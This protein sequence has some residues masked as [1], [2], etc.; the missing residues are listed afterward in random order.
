MRCGMRFSAGDDVLQ[1]PHH[2]EQG[3]SARFVAAVRAPL[4]A[5]GEKH[6]V[7][8]EDIAFSVVL[9]FF[10]QGFGRHRGDGV[11][12][13]EH[14]SSSTGAAGNP[15][16]FRKNYA[17]I[18]QVF[19]FADEFLHQQGANQARQQLQK[20]RKWYARMWAEQARKA[21]NQPEIS[22]LTAALCPDFR[23]MRT[24]IC[25]KSSGLTS[26]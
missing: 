4:R 26:R 17:D 1:L 23:W 24:R 3:D 13:C 14:A 7:M 8:T 15:A 21:A 10:A 9:Y 11:F 5:A 19:A 20:A 18:A 16:K 12:Y 6:I 2:L 25:R 22:R